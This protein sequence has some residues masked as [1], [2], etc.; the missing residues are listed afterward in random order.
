MVLNLSGVLAHQAGEGKL[1][2][3]RLERA[4]ELEPD[5]GTFHN[6]IGKVF[7]NLGELDQAEKHLRKC[8]EIAPNDAFAHNNMGSIFLARTNY[9][10]AI[11][12]F[13]PYTPDRSQIW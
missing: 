2:I 4:L 11:G 9:A 6:N 13:N 3:R 10:E 8:L 7:R 1:A 12:S 5:N